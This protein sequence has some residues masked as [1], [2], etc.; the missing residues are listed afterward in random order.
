MVNTKLRY[1]LLVLMVAGR[2]LAADNAPCTRVRMADVGW[3]DITATT[4]V[5]SEILRSVGVQPEVRVL[6]LPVTFMSVKNDDI[7]VFLGNWIPTQTNDIKPYLDAHSVVDLTVNLTGALYT[8]AVPRYVYDAGVKSANDLAAHKAKF[9]GKIYGIE[10]GNEGNRLVLDMIAKNTYGLSGWTLVESSEQGMLTEVRHAVDHS[11]W[12]VYMGWRPHPMNTTI[13][14]EYLKDPLEKWGPGGGASTVHTIVSKGFQARCPDLC[15][16]FSQLH[17][18]VDME[19]ELMRAILDEHRD[20][21]QV[22]RDWIKVHSA[23]VDNWLRGTKLIRASD[24]GA[25]DGSH[26]MGFRVPLGPWISKGVEFLTRN[27]AD[28]LR[29]VSAVVTFTIQCVIR[30]LAAVPPPVLILLMVAATWWWHRSRSLAAGMLFGSLVI[31]NL[32]YW[33]ATIDTLALVLTASALSMLI[34]VPIGILAARHPWLFT[35]LRPFLDTMQTI[36]TFVY[37]IPTLMLFGLGLVPGLLSTVIFAVPAPIR[38]TYLGI[39]SVPP[40]LIEAGHAFG[41]TPWQILKK[42]EIP[43]ALPTIMEGVTQ[44]LML[45]LSMVVIAALVGA[46]GLGTPV[47]RALNTVNVE[48]GFEAG[49]AIVIVAILLDRVVKKPRRHSAPA[50]GEHI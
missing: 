7:D 23:E 15:R 35:L 3:T 43:H 34:G 47:V 26:P 31:W 50:N 6:S 1:L 36:P 32:G 8:F 48:Q 16:F 2:A 46:E 20:P 40:E 29:Q 19:N 11:E 13:L 27:F 49:L 39:V 21:N 14:M 5:A 25:G 42:I 33:R 10:P 44:S 4:A 30:P 38:L 9:K 22:A 45:S 41:A 37:L 28:Q 18:T 12:I 24:A 17:F